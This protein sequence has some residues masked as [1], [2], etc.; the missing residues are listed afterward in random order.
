[1][2]LLRRSSQRFFSKDLFSGFSDSYAKYRPDYPEDLFT[3]L[4]SLTNN[5]LVAW[6]VATG[7]GQAAKSLSKYY[8]TVIAT[9]SSASQINS[10]LPKDSSN[11]LIFEHLPAELPKEVV[12][13]HK[14]LTYNNVD[15]ITVAQAMHWFNLEK[16]YDVVYKVLKTDGII[17]AWSYQLPEVSS[18]IDKIMMEIYEN[19]LGEKYWSP[20]LKHVDNGYANLDFPFDRNVSLPPTKEIIKEWNFEDYWNYLHTWSGLQTAIKNSNQDPSQPF[21]DKFLEIWGKN[22]VKTVKFPMK[23]LIGRLQFDKE[24]TEDTSIKEINSY[25]KRFSFFRAS[26]SVSALNTV[27]HLINKISNHFDVPTDEEIT[28]ILEYL[29]EIKDLPIKAESDNLIM[30]LLKYMVL[31]RNEEFLIK[32]ISFLSKVTIN[33]SNLSNFMDYVDPFITLIVKGSLEIFAKPFFN[34]ICSY[35]NSIPSI[36]LKNKEIVHLAASLARA[37]GINSR[38]A[39]KIIYMSMNWDCKE[40]WN[41]IIVLSSCTRDEKIW[42][43]IRKSILPQTASTLISAPK[44]LFIKNVVNY[45]YWPHYEK[46]LHDMAFKCICK[47]FERKDLKWED[48]EEV[49]S[50]VTDRFEV[51]HLEHKK[52]LLYGSLKLYGIL[53]E[54]KKI[55]QILDI[56]TFISK[57]STREFGTFAALYADLGMNYFKFTDREKVTILECLGK[58][59]VQNSEIFETICSEILAGPEKYSKYYPQI[60]NAIAEANYENEPWAEH[61]KKLISDYV[62]N[63][64]NLLQKDH[65]SLKLLWALIKCD[66]P[67]NAIEIAAKL[68]PEVDMWKK[69]YL[70]RLACYY[71]F[72]DKNIEFGKK[73]EFEAI[74][75]IL[76]NENEWSMKKNWTNNIVQAFNKYNVNYS[77]FEEIDGFICPIGLPSLKTSIFITTNQNM[78]YEKDLPRGDFAMLERLKEKKGI[79]CLQINGEWMKYEKGDMLDEW[80]ASN[81]IISK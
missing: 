68:V 73:T 18:E 50:F 21:Y 72:A 57:I 31:R 2:K 35:L 24:I 11:S 49:Y 39:D 42:Q 63:N 28:D 37:E 19:V 80:L 1:M 13:S 78:N 67:L 27:K 25:I 55:N 59:S 54:P 29:T 22:E 12:D 43:Y 79:R 76:K 75:N 64:P 33:D 30:S 4:S 77:L 15:L 44:N 8:S 17:A 66:A 10:A 38:L 32:Y 47:F 48:V 36:S 51:R 40:S 53:Y 62:I 46:E 23:F 65:N 71:Y 9:D 52:A 7:S 5:H 14:Y 41:D 69:S 81:S 70:K 20:L 3:H 16:F 56:L 26:Q 45:Y 6:D 60:L 34:N 61:I 74:K 58:R